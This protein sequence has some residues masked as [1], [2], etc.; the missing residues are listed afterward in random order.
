MM[1]GPSKER[2]GITSAPKWCDACERAHDGSANDARILLGDRGIIGAGYAYAYDHRRGGYNL[3]AT[4]DRVADRV[5]RYM[6]AERPNATGRK[7][8]LPRTPLRTSQGNAHRALRV[9]RLHDLSMLW[10]GCSWD[11]AL[12][13]YL[14]AR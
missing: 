10:G 8:H 12:T 3:C 5:T 9:V 11:D 13:R 14:A 6:I 4:F 2:F 1:R 7:T